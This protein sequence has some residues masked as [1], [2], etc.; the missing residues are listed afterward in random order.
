MSEVCRLWKNQSIVRHKKT[1]SPESRSARRHIRDG[2]G[3]SSYVGPRLH[4]A[5]LPMSASLHRFSPPRPSSAKLFS[6]GPTF[7]F[8]LVPF[9]GQ[10][11]NHQRRL[12]SGYVQSNSASSLMFAVF[13]MLGFWRVLL[14]FR[15]M[16]LLCHTLA[17][18]LKAVLAWSILFLAS[19]VLPPS[20]ETLAPKCEIV[21]LL[22]FTVSCS[23][24]GV[25]LAVDFQYLVFLWV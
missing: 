14:V 6:G 21:H 2:R 18:L 4:G 7:Y 22:H 3:L 10:Q 19:A 11:C 25:A 15:P 23:Q 13:A 9:E 8:L 16:S 24:I 17:S 5:F 12:S 1:S 20:L